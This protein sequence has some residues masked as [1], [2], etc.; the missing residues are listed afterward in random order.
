LY[1]VGSEIEGGFTVQSATNETG[2]HSGEVSYTVKVPVSGWT[3]QYP[4][5]QRSVNISGVFYG[6]LK[7]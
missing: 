2:V 6:T 7:D 1:E 3:I 4:N 5:F